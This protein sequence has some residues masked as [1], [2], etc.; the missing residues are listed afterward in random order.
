MLGAGIRPVTP[1]AA[2]PVVGKFSVGEAVTMEV[3]TLPAKRRTLLGTKHARRMRQQGLIPAIIYGH[4]GE[5]I[6][7]AIDYH[8]VEKILQH[9]SRVLNLDIDSQAGQYLIKAVQYD[10]LG[11]TPVHLDLMRVDLDERV[12]LNVEVVLKGTAKGAHEGGLVLQPLNTIEVECV[13]T[14]IPEEIKHS[15]VDLGLN[16]TVQVK[17]LHLPEGVTAITDPEETVAVC[18]IP[19][20]APA[21]EEEGAEEEAAEGGEPEVIGRKEEEASESD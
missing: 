14:A 17:D 5:A 2:R 16:E 13:V 15:I 1:E 11:T 20:E 9:H 18:R 6:P 4:G 8:E 12:T 10:H 7:V 3:T 21:E 19:T